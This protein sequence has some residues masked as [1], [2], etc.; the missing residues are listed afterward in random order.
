MRKALITL[1]ILMVSVGTFS[2][3]E[4]FDPGIKESS[5]AYLVVEGAILGGGQP[6]TI[7]LSRT[8]DLTTTNFVAENGASVSVEDEPGN[9]YYLS[10]QGSGV[11]SGIFSNLTEG[12]KVRLRIRTQDGK[13]YLSDFET[14]KNTPEID[15]VAWSVN[16]SHGLDITVDTHDDQNN[17][18]YYRWAYEQT[19]EFHSTY[20]STLDY[21]EKTR[22]IVPRTNSDGIYACWQSAK[23]NSVLVN[24]TAKLSQDRVKDFRL[25]TIPPKSWYLDVLYSILVKQYAL[26]EAEYNYWQKIKKNTEEIGSIFDPLPS[27]IKGNLQCLSDPNELVIGYVGACVEREKRI[28][29][30]RQDIDNWGYYQS[31]TVIDVANNPDSLAAVFAGGSMEPFSTT[32]DNAGQERYLGTDAVCVDCTIRGTNVKPSFWP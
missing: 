17:T 8:T 9:I 27:E 5:K 19:W 20:L 11:Y 29:I 21:D 7:T 4:P 25:V 13:E 10:P 18:H 6:T 31:C 3:R 26:S 28:F 16:S 22:Q 15:N 14:M 1:I 32:L 23:S 12:T 24:S 2:C 30:A